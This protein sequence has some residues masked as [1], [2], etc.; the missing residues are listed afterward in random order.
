MADGKF[1]NGKSYV[2]GYDASRAFVA[3]ATGTENYS[4]NLLKA[5]AKVD[6]KNR[7]RVYVRDFSTPSLRDHEVAKQSR[8]K[9][10]T[11]LSVARNDKAG[12]GWPSNFEFRPIRPHRFWTQLGLALETWKNPVDLLFV[13]AHTLPILR[14]RSFLKGTTSS[15]G[16]TGIKGLKTQKARGTRDTLGARD[17]RYVVTIHDLG[18][19]YLPGHHQF[20]Q[21]YYLDLASKYAARHAD[22]LIA[23]SAAT[24]DDL[25]KRYKVDA[26]KV[27]AV[28]EG[29]DAAFFRPSSKLKVK[30]V[31][32]KYKIKGDYILFVGTVQPRKNLLMLIRAFA[33]LVG[34]RQLVVSR[35]NKKTTDYKLRTTNLVIAGKLGW[36]YADILAAPKKYGIEKQVKFL[37]H[38]DTGDLPALYS[39]AKVFAFPSLF[40]G[41]GL[42]ILEAIS[43]GCPVIASDIGP[44]REIFDK[45]SRNG[46]WPMANGKSRENLEAIVLVKPNDVDKWASVLYQY[47]SQYRKS[48]INISQKGQLLAEF[49]WEQTAKKTLQVFEQVIR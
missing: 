7:Y 17:T 13:P 24:R 42:P 45:F 6:R 19:E 38:V 47:I 12:Q 1:L 41:F 18:V 40:E 11:L 8:Q 14:R 22:A 35:R 46:Q 32:S 9:I 3:E 23:V 21:R 39:G 36:D 4:L 33:N 30:S 25:I 27:F 26:K 20:P 28:H 29:V 49:S 31:K 43:C 10:A 16:T 34:S 44:H 48:Q 37:G 15:Q 2:I 5:L